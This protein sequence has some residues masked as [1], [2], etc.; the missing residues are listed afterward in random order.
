MESRYYHPPF[1]I[2]FTENTVFELS[3]S[4]GFMIENL[5]STD[6]EVGP[7]G[8]EVIPLA[9]G[10]ARQFEAPEGGIY[11]GNY[12]IKIATGSG[13]VLVVRN[14]PVGSIDRP[15]STDGSINHQEQII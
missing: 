5:G 11:W 1:P 12:S 14:T 6:I 4:S 7:E 9:S 10:D 8:N 3:G 15:E 13:K 2:V